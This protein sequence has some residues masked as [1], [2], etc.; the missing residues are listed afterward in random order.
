MYARALYEAAKD[1][2]RLAPVREELGD[3]VEAQR[4]VPEL[5]EL[6]RNPQLDQRVKASALEELLGGEEKL[7]R[8]FLLLLAE[9]GRAGEVE[10]IARE[11]ERLAAEEEGILDVQLTT[12][13]ELSDAEAGD[14][15][16][17][18][19]KA[20]GRTVE[21]TRRVDP[22]LIGGI[23]LQAG[24]MRLDAS[25]RGRL[26]RLRHELKGSAA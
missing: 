9:K 3:F 5:R 23:V 18:I 22:D 19:E 15:V 17:Q 24:S 4:Q 1:E 2:D 21:A 7:V 6:L 25:V 26:E 14:V 20:S 13:V 10:E 12:A 11:F 8:N 16:R